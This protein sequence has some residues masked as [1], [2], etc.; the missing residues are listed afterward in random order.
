MLQDFGEHLAGSKLVVSIIVS[1]L[2]FTVESLT[3][4]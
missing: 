4:L 1:P 2:L 3:N